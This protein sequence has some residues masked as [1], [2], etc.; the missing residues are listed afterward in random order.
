MAEPAHPSTIALSLPAES[1][2][3][4]VTLQHLQHAERRPSR[5]WVDQAKI[6]SDA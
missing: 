6:K 3:E 2:A 5:P 1:A 4:P